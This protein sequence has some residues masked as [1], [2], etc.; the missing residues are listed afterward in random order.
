MDCPDIRCTYLFPAVMIVGLAV[1]A[2]F[3]PLLIIIF[4]IRCF[5]SFFWYVS[6]NLLYIFPG[7]DYRKLLVVLLFFLAALLFPFFQLRNNVPWNQ[8]SLSSATR[9]S[10]TRYRSFF[11]RPLKGRR[12]LQFPKRIGWYIGSQKLHHKFF[13]VCQILCL[14]SI[15]LLLNACVKINHMT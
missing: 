5:S 13:H 8:V 12:D 7:T 3:Q 1:I 11:S 6:S 2:A 10:R 14:Y 15:F 4:L 9:S